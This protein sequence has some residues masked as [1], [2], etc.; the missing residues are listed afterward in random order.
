M[1]GKKFFN[2]LGYFIK[3]NGTMLLFFCF[4]ILMFFVLFEKDKKTA[5]DLSLMDKKFEKYIIEK[6]EEKNELNEKIK[7]INED[8]IIVKEELKNLDNFVSIINDTNIKQDKDISNMKGKQDLLTDFYNKMGSRYIDIQNS[9]LD[10]QF[11]ISKLNTP[12]IEELD[13][14]NESI[15]CLNN[16]MLDIDQSKADKIDFEKLNERVSKIENIDIDSI[17]LSI[18]NLEDFKIYISDYE[19][20]NNFVQDLDCIKEGFDII[21]KMQQQINKLQ[22]DL[23][24]QNNLGQAPPMIHNIG[25]VEKI[26]DF[27]QNKDNVLS[28]NIFL[29]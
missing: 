3:N 23:E 24:N 19:N 10:I 16:I 11:K 26:E 15:N 14:I 6:E 20:V 8:F 21:L 9:L 25:E 18:K 29:K 2:D 4:I 17:I 13:N 28:E 12:S 5:E 27:E 7:I 22:V 1:N